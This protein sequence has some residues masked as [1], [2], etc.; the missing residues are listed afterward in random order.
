[1]TKKLINLGIILAMVISLIL[2][3][4]QKASAAEAITVSHAIANNSG[5]ATVEGYIVGIVKA[6]NSFQHEG[7]F[8][9]DTNIAIADS[10]NEKDK[11]KILPVQLPIGKVREGLNLKSNPSNLGKKIQITGNLEPYFSM[12]GHKSATAFTFVDGSTPEPQVEV[13]TSSVTGEIVSKGTNVT[14]TT[15][16]PDAAIY[17]TLDGSNPTSD[18]S[19]YSTPIT[20]NEDVT[21]KAI[22]IKEGLKNSDVAT[23]K[24]QVAL[25]GLRIHDIQGASHQSPYANKAVEGVEGIVTKVVDSSNFYMQDLKP[26]IDAKTSEGIL[27]YKK[28]HGQAVGNVISVNGTV[29]EWVLEGYSDKLKTD[30]AVTEINADY[31]RIASIAEG[32]ELPESL[33]IGMFGLQQPAQVIDNDDFAEFD[34]DE[35]GI[36]FYE[37]I[38][39]MLVEINNPAVIAPQNYGELVVLPDSGKGSRLNSAGGLN[40]T[41]FDYNP[42]RIFVDI[43]DTSFVAKSGDYFVGTISGVVSY[44]FGNYK[45]LADREELPT[46]VEG[47][48]ERETS[49]FHE[50]HKELTIASFNVENFSANTS[51][52]SDEKV[53]RIADSIIS[54]LKSPDIVGLVEMQDGNGAINNGYTEATESAVRLIEEIK[55]QGGPEYV[56]TDVAPENNQD[57]GQPGGNIRVGFIYNPER[58]TLAEGS[59]GSATQAVG[60]NDGK[61]TLNPGRIDPTNPAFEDSRKPLAAQFMFKGESVIVVA[62]HFNSKGGDQPLFG[63]NQPPFLGS[64]AQRLE[65]AG[66]VNDFVQDVKKEDKNAKV[67]LLGDF[68]DFEFTPA[69]ET[70]KGEELTNMIEEVPLD[71]RFTYS[72]Q[73]NAQVLDHILVT[74]N[75]AKKTKVDIVHINS[76][77]M[78]EHGRAS[79]H[80]PVL[81]QVKLDKVK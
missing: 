27:V 33:L 76:Q 67:V 1:M 59:K 62:N 70:L 50:K 5:T 81:I 68:N 54:N 13:I 28:G 75:M 41:E 37:S 18:S 3:L 17:F 15:A 80:D 60:Y 57:G 71:E 47:T 2:P 12:P 42:E 77:F 20:V 34:P 8:T 64:E 53:S 79:D 29:K 61:L 40:I 4:Q 38:E 14:L 31:G 52:T 51:D 44:G 66:V 21:I 73:G 9:T 11:T 30:L 45:V 58:V 22:A 49:R 26:D 74:N 39:G 35:D 46:L 72:Y 78:E 48:T 19:R 36:D 56:Y 55:A 23:F 65:I 63:K 16:T 69:L 32:Q 43:D 7:P 24:Y 25:S 10:P 6:T